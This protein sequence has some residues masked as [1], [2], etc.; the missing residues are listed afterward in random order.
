MDY[1]IAKSIN[2]IGTVAG[3]GLVGLGAI[4]FFVAA[5]SDF[6]AALF[7]G[8][9]LA[10]SGLALVAMCQMANAT[11]HTAEQSRETNELLR[12]LLRSNTEGAGSVLIG[13]TTGVIGSQSAALRLHQHKPA[14]ISRV[15]SGHPVIDTYKDVNIEKVDGLERFVVGGKYFLSVAEAKE[16]IDRSFGVSEASE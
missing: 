11:I 13:G 7:S 2:A 15:S 9:V 16:Y 1:S 8:G 10:F 4:S 6:L 12:Q 3:W 14:A 5:Q